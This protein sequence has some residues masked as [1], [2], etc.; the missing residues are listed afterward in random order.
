MVP[1]SL[2]A[3]RLEFLNYHLHPPYQLLTQ[4]KLGINGRTQL[5]FLCPRLGSLL[6]LETSGG[7]LWTNRMYSIICCSNGTR[8]PKLCYENGGGSFLIPYLVA[9]PTLTLKRIH[10]QFHNFHCNFT[11]DAFGLW[12]PPLLLGT[13]AWTILGLRTTQGHNIAFMV[14][15]VC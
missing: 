2:S 5:T 10:C 4:N 9:F 13:H 7:D 6:V 1:S 12:P 11:A 3:P 8:F 15:R 14:Y